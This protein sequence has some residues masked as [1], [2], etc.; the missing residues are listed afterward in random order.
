MQKK[1]F[2]SEKRYRFGGS[3]IAGSSLT[4]YVGTGV[5]P[6][7]PFLDFGARCYDSWTATWLSQDPMAEKYY[8]LSAY[9]YC[10]E[11][12]VNLLDKDGQDIIIRGADG[13]SVMIFIPSIDKE[14]DI[15]S[16]GF[17]FQGNYF[18][19]GLESANTFFDMMGIADP[20]F[21]CDG[22]S[23][24]LYLYQGKKKDAL[25][26]GL[27]ILP[28]LGDL[29]KIKHIDEYL[30]LYK[31]IIHKHHVIPKAVY[32]NMEDLWT[33][34]G[35]NKELMAVPAGFHGN[36]PK[37]SKWIER[38]LQ[39]MIARD[40]KLTPD[41][42]NEVIKMAKIEINNAFQHYLKTKENMNKYFESLL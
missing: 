37:Y 1:R 8:S 32:K 25:L 3:E 4:D 29:S 15:S 10:A 13:S 33:A 7:T 38:K 6:G 9:E 24:A 23:A 11:N 31:A 16:T 39:D 18:F 2:N 27:A 22:I 12:P 17:S 28:Y 26:S 42:V 30:D 14:W 35:K 19:D 41:N 20:S 21:V 36:H 34:M 5:S 40:G